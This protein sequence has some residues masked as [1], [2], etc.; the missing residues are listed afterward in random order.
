MKITIW[1]RLLN[2]RSFEGNIEK[3][4]MIQLTGTKSPFSNVFIQIGV[5]GTIILQGINT[6]NN[7][8]FSLGV[9]GGVFSLR[10]GCFCGVH[11]Y[12]LNIYLS[13]KRFWLS[14]SRAS[15]LASS[16]FLKILQTSCLWV[17]CA[18]F[19]LSKSF[20]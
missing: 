11:V 6:K 8:E 18:C 7:I 3:T 5:S 1:I 4:V 15:V 16:Y 19:W 13:G 9:C 14:D 12:P 20:L 17:F 2:A 10:F